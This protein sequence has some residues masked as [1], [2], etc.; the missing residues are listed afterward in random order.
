MPNKGHALV[1]CISVTHYDMAVTLLVIPVHILRYCS[2]IQLS[3]YHNIVAPKLT[4]IMI[5]SNYAIP[6]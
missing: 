3:N 4:E 1:F 6:T 2:D 5:D